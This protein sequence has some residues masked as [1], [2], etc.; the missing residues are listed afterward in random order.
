MS[1]GA[2]QISKTSSQENVGYSKETKGLWLPNHFLIYCT[3]AAFCKRR[4]RVFSLFFFSL[5]HSWFWSFFFFFLVWSPFENLNYEPRNHISWESLYLDQKKKGEKKKNILCC[6]AGKGNNKE[7][8]S[9]KWKIRGR[10]YYLSLSPQWLHC[11][12]C[13]WEK[14]KYILAICRSAIQ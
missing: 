5:L 13:S 14:N 11:V 10:F 8:T 12:S 1:L 3:G 9:I 4:S 2:L 6:S 7:K